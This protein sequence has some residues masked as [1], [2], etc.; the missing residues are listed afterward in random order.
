MAVLMQRIKAATGKSGFAQA[1]EYG[2]LRRGPG[3]ITF[4]EYFAFRLYDDTLYT[5][6]MKADFL[7]ETMHWPLCHRCADPHWR[8]ATE[9]KWLAYT[10]LQQFG[11]RVPDTLAVV[12]RSQRS[13]GK[14]Q[15]IS[16]AAEL[17]SFLNAASLPIFAKPNGELASFGSMII[18]RGTGSL[19][20]LNDGRHLTAEQIFEQVIGART[21]LLQA[22]VRNHPEIAR[23]A[24]H[25]PTVR[26]VNLIWSDRIE[27]LFT[28]LKLPLGDNIADNYWRKGN[29][30]A[31]LDPETG[32]FMRVVSGK[33]TDLQVHETHPET[34]ERLIGM[35]LPMWGE[36]LDVNRVCASAFA[37]VRY[38]SLDIALTPEGPCVIEVN[39]GG[40][41]FLPQIATGRGFLS[42]DVRGFLRS[43]GWTKS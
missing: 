8:A 9:D 31:D 35:R 11:V 16:N 5:K 27:T 26:T 30:L 1:M 42:P 25:V 13:F 33:G 18:D 29:L 22:V 23:L 41:F 39:S 40:S 14:T 10:L 34:G 12:D 24:R 6:E 32:E 36:L 19:F 43:C 21:Y 28:L 4:E 7:S 37:A 20:R 3:K 17:L 15:K 38:Q 2:R